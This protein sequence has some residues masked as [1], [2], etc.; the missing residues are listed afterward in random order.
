[1]TNMQ[2]ITEAAILNGLYT[3]DEALALLTENGELPLHTFAEWK[4]MGY[5]VRKGEKARMSCSIW[6]YN[7]KSETVQQKDGEEKEVDKSHFYK[8]L[9]HFFTAEQVEKLEKAA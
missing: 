1:M 4:R 8:Q 6:R 9:A 7:K 2:I 5:T 3:E